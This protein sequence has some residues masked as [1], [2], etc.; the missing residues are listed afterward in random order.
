[1]K[2][3]LISKLNETIVTGEILSVIYHGGSQPGSIRQLIPI[4]VTSREVRAKEIPSNAVK[5]FLVA[6]MELA[7]SSSSAKQ[8][9]PDITSLSNQPESIREAF[10][11]QVSK[12]TELGWHVELVRDAISLHRYFKN[13]KVRKGA[14]VGITK[15]YDNPSRP[16]YVYGPSFASARTFGKLT[17]A[18]KLFN[19]ESQTHAP[20]NSI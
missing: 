11:D 18:I 14:D 16:F 19:E 20:K 8:Y 7:T 10:Q 1:M 17:S 2:E 3:E 15:Y 9:N 6:K 4:K 12:L 13:G 5:T